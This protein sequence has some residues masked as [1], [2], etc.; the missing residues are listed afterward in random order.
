MDVPHLKLSVHHL[1]CHHRRAHACRCRCPHRSHPPRA[2]APDLH[3]PL[4]MATAVAFSIGRRLLSS[5]AVEAKSEHTILTAHLRCLARAG[6]LDEIDAFLTPQCYSPPSSLPPPRTSTLSSV[7]SHNVE[8]VCRLHG[9]HLL[10]HSE[11]FSRLRGEHP[12]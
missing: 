5:A 8:E 11:P 10:H 9:P 12:L 1:R 7:R 6:S 2:A 3:I 4:A